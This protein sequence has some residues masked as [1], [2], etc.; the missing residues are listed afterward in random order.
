MPSKRTPPAET[1]AANTASPGSADDPVVLK[2]APS[3]MK[4]IEI[5]RGPNRSG[6]DRQAQNAQT[7]DKED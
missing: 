3:P 1:A 7:R 6:M 5:T 4:A 2:E